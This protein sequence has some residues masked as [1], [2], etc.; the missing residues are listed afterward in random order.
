MM[1]ILFTPRPP[2][3]RSRVISAAVCVCVLCGQQRHYNE[4]HWVLVNNNN[5]NSMFWLF[6]MSRRTR[7][8]CNL[9]NSI[10]HSNLATSTNLKHIP[11][12]NIR[13]YSTYTYIYMLRV[14][15]RFCVW[16]KSQKYVCLSVCVWVV[17]SDRFIVDTVD[18]YV[19][20]CVNTLRFHVLRAMWICLCF[21]WFPLLLQ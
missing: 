16:T 5:H 4:P 15:F 8:A 14:M 21:V 2:K 11:Q 6:I 12:F 13:I 18:A 19:Q 1:F 20:P 7:E 3:P 17:F 10:A 9:L